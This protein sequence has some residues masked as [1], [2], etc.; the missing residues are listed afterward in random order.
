MTIQSLLIQ[1]TLIAQAATATE[2]DKF[3]RILFEHEELP[4]KMVWIDPGYRP[5]GV[6]RGDSIDIYYI[7]E[8]HVG[9]YYQAERSTNV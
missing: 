1:K 6:V 3:G 2:I 9:G 4:N 5:P 7:Y 8:A